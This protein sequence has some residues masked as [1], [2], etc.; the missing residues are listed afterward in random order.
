MAAALSG[1][2]ERVPGELLGQGAE[3]VTPALLYS[4]MAPGDAGLR[5]GANIVPGSDHT[6]LPLPSG[7]GPSATE[8]ATRAP[9]LASFETASTFGFRLPGDSAGQPATSPFSSLDSSDVGLADGN[10]L[11]GWGLATVMGGPDHAPLWAAMGIT[12]QEL[13]NQLQTTPWEVA[14]FQLGR[15][16][17]PRHFDAA[18]ALP[19]PLGAL[20][21]AGVDPRVALTLQ[22]GWEAVVLGG[23]DPSPGANCHRCGSNGDLRAV[24][25]CARW[26]PHFRLAPR[27]YPRRAIGLA[28]RRSG[29]LVLHRIRPLWRREVPPLWSRCPA[30]DSPGSIQPVLPSWRLR[31]L[32][33]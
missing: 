8:A 23:R 14:A 33:C 24:T 2:V 6:A 21:H 4:V 25:N 1:T 10:P 9:V 27:H 30:R 3:A 16:V 29:C 22:A 28:S 26:L 31:M 15:P 18:V 11:L 32:P 13:V 7:S 12:P 20:L 17:T 5:L 19:G